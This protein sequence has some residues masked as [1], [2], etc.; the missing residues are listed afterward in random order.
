MAPRSLA[1]ALLQTIKHPVIPNYKE[2]APTPCSSRIYKMVCQAANCV[3]AQAST[4][5]CGARPALECNCAKASVE[6]V[7]PA[8]SEA[9][10]C[11]K[12]LKNKCSCGAQPCEAKEGETDFTNA[13]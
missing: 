10:A 2:A 4:C 13:A 9:C 5:S 12:R 6:N 1:A 3:C 8:A 7:A 11:G